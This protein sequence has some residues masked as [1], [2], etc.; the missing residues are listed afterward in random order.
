MPQNDNDQ[1]DLYKVY[2]LTGGA[3]IVEY[4]SF[5]LGLLQGTELPK[6]V[7]TLDSNGTEDKGTFVDETADA[8][9]SSGSTFTA[10]PAPSAQYDALYICFDKPFTGIST[11]INTAGTDAGSL[12]ATWEYPNTVDNNDNPATWV[13]LVEDDES[14]SLTAGT[15]TYSTKWIIPTDWVKSTMTIGANDEKLTGYWVKFMVGTAGYTVAPILESIG[16]VMPKPGV[17]ATI[18]NNI[19]ASCDLHMNSTLTAG[20]VTDKDANSVTAGQGIHVVSEREFLYNITIKN[21][22]GGATGEL[23]VGWLSIEQEPVGGSTTSPAYTRI[24][25]GNG[26]TLAD[27]EPDQ[28]F[29]MDRGVAK[30]TQSS[31]TLQDTDKTWTV[32]AFAGMTVVAH[33][34]SALTESHAIVSNTA[35]TITITGPWATTPVT[36]VTHYEVRTTRNALV[37]RLASGSIDIDEL[38]VDISPKILH[39]KSSTPALLDN[40]DTQALA[41]QYGIQ[42]V[43]PAPVN[44]GT[45][46]YT[47]NADGTMATSAI[48]INGKTYTITYVWNANGTIASSSVAVT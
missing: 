47:W 13:D 3:T 18:R 23:V 31:T 36:N 21:L 39:Y 17:F 26:T 43:A 2:S 11:D 1:M 7:L 29:R 38:N 25:D 40:Q 5:D 16:I 6:W 15:S 19:T 4:P 42:I 28:V 27:V 30:G 34:E 45:Y 33:T 32:N 10:I 44:M 48:L 9:S 41:N 35:N 37:V 12:A 14:T 46:T 20:A 22:A 24:Q 8:R